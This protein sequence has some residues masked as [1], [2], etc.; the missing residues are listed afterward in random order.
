MHVF[1]DLDGNH[2]DYNGD[3][4]YDPNHKVGEFISNGMKWVQYSLNNGHAP[5]NNLFS[6]K[7]NGVIYEVSSQGCSVEEIKKLL[8]TFEQAPTE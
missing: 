4:Q 8:E 5:Y 1:E 3:F 2:P 6:T 7:V